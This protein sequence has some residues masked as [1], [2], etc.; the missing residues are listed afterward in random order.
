MP[1]NAGDSHFVTV[2]RHAHLVET[3][4]PGLEALPDGE[5]EAIWRNLDSALRPSGLGLAIVSIPRDEVV[6]LFV[7]REEGASGALEAETPQHAA[8][9]A[10]IECAPGAVVQRVVDSLVVLPYD[11]RRD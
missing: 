8:I 5:T 3:Y 1:R 2:Q 10:V 7:W 4:V 6:L 11:D 9:R